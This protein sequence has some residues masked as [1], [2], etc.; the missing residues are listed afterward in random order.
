MTAGPGRFALTPGTRIVAA[1]GSGAA[2]VAQDLAGYLRPATGYRLPV[3]SGSGGRDAITVRLS[4]SAAV[5]GD[6]DHEGYR[7]SVSA[8]GVS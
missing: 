4:R 1:A 8:S 7:L 2:P 6:P 5:P 3:V